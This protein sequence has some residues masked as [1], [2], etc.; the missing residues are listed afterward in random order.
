MVFVERKEVREATKDWFGLDLQATTAQA[1]PWRSWIQELN[2]SLSFFYWICC[3]LAILEIFDIQHLM[4][5]YSWTYMSLCSLE[6]VLAQDKR[7]TT[8]QQK[9]FFKEVPQFPSCLHPNQSP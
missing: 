6:D 2:I 4:I 1:I 7:G 9:T 5:A 8:S 3:Q